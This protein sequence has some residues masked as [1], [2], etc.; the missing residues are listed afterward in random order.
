MINI[1]FRQ[2]VMRTHSKR[3]VVNVLSTTFKSTCCL[4][5]AQLFPKSGHRGLFNIIITITI[6]I[7]KALF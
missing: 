4:F 6:T 7:I 3:D 1:E 5:G 2:E